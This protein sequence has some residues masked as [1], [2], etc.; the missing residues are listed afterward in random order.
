[1]PVVRQ[2]SS[3]HD[4]KALPMNSQQYTC[5]NSICIWTTPADMPAWMGEIWEKQN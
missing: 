2:L 4:Q 5:L 3:K 1:M